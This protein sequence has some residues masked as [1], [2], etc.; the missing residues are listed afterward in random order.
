MHTVAQ[1]A[2]VVGARLGLTGQALEQLR[3]TAELH[4]IGKIAIPD[5]VLGK[6]GVLTEE[7]WRFVRRHSVVGQRILTG[8]PVL[9]EVAGIVRATHE[10]W[11]GSGYPD[12]LA[13]TAIPLA[14]R[15]IAVCD[16]Y[17]AMTTERPYRTALDPQRALGELRR[18]AGT[19]FDPE[20]VVAFTR[21]HGA[22]VRSL[23]PAPSVIGSG[24]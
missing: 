12:G 14:A 20:V 24:G 18:C 16:A 22:V 9:R 19:Q 13:A 21:L 23:A 6:P 3:L 10:R 17:V 15:I 4:D 5:A 7:E 2:M 8:S 1:F 11:D